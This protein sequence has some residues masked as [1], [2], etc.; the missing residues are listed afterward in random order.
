MNI[1]LRLFDK[2]TNN[3]IEGFMNLG[4][5]IDEPF[6]TIQKVKLPPSLPTMVLLENE[7]L[8]R[9][10]EMELYHSREY[11]DYLFNPELLNED[12][13]ESKE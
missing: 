7:V 4:V 12:S 5:V 2:K 11:I 1:K 3:G 8:K 10:K 13:E 9:N 6:S